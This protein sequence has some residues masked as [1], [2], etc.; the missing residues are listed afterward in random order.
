MDFDFW[1]EF[2][3][4]IIFVLV[5]VPSILAVLLALTPL[6][7]RRD[8]KRLKQWANE[9]SLVLLSCRSRFFLRGPFVWNTPFMISVFRLDVMTPDSV[10]HRGWVRCGTSMWF[11]SGRKQMDARWDPPP[12]GF[13]VLPIHALQPPLSNPT[14]P[15]SRESKPS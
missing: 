10:V 8:R 4:Q 1:Q 14:I 7:A 13:A 12:Q 15:T 2:R 3:P 9:H 6:R 5:S 11:K